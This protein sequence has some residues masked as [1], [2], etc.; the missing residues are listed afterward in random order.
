MDTWKKL[1]VGQDIKKPDPIKTEEQLMV[2]PNSLA[3]IEQIFDCVEGVGWDM[4]C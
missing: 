4:S 1:S 3:N 2:N